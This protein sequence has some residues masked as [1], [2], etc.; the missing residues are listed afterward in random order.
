[1]PRELF[2]KAKL[3]PRRFY[4]PKVPILCMW[5]ILHSSKYCRKADIWNHFT[6]VNYFYHMHS[7]RRI[8]QPDSSS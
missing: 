6:I 2:I 7:D 1:M 5:A 3:V 8:S 4:I